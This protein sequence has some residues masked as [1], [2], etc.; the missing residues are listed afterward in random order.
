MHLYLMR[1][2][3]AFPREDPNCP[4]EVERPL[5]EKGI[6]KA[7]EVA[8]GLRRLGVELDGI[9]ASPFLRTHQTAALVG[10]VFGI[11]SI[12]LRKELI[13]GTPTERVLEMVA[14]LEHRSVLLVSHSPLVDEL[15]SAIL[16]REGRMFTAMKT[17]GVAAFDIDPGPTVQGDLLWYAPPKLLRKAGTSKGMPDQAELQRRLPHSVPEDVG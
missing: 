8:S 12:E 5:T 6:I 11:P 15:T 17:A 1:H 14:S 9:V 16:T 3:K 4:P 13:Y 2:S 10:E 7:W